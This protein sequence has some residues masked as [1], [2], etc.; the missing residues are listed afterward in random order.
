M[1]KKILSLF[2]HSGNMVQPWLDNGH[3]CTIVDIKHEPGVVVDGNLTIIGCDMREFMPK[4]KYDIVFAFPPCTHLAS[5]GA[6]WWKQKGL[7]A[8]IEGLSL[9][10]E[11]GRIIIQA[12]CD[13]WMI[14]NPVGRLS[15]HWR[16]PNHKFHPYQY[17]GYVTPEADHYTKQTCL[18]T[19]DTFVMPEHKPA[20]PHEGSRMHKL[21][22]RDEKLYGLRSKTPMGFATAIYEANK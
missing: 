7:D 3:D 17:G 16:K 12:N 20:D 19:S 14:E 10:S 21:W 1:K 6:R 22:S 11:A 4:E 2:D 8:L 18:W 15:T 13:V 9:V 5:L